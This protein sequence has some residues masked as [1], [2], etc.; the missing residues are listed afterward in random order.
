MATP[1]RESLLVRRV[2]RLPTAYRSVILQ[3]IARCEN[4]RNE[5]SIRCHLQN[6]RNIIASCNMDDGYQKLPI[7]KKKYYFTDKQ[8][9]SKLTIEQMARRFGKS[10]KTIYYWIYTKSSC[11]NNYEVTRE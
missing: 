1:D 6:A 5:D 2:Y 10:I 7:V 9:Q 11:L 4:L 3:L 8:T